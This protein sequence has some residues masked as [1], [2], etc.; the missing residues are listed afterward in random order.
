VD[1]DGVR[2][3]SFQ[4]GTYGSARALERGMKIERATKST[5]IDVVLLVLLAL[6]GSIL[7]RIG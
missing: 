2:F 5:E 4:H 3:L 7:T 6:A 1:S